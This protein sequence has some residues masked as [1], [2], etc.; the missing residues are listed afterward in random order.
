MRPRFVKTRL[1]AI[2]ALLA[3][4]SCVGHYTTDRAAVAYNRAFANGRNEVLLLNILR[5][6]ADEPLQFSTISSVGGQVLNGTEVSIPFTNILLGGEDSITPTLKITGRNP[7][8]TVTPL[9]TREFVRGMTRSISIDTIV[10]LIDQGWDR[11]TVLA[12]AVGGVVCADKPRNVVMNDG[13]NRD[14]NSRFISALQSAT[15]VARDASA[16]TVVATLQMTSAEAAAMLA[17][18]VGEGRR[19]GRILPIVPAAEEKPSA[20]TRPRP[21]RVPP[22]P[23]ANVSVEIVEPGSPRLSGLQFG[24]LCGTGAPSAAAVEKAGGAGIILRSIQSMIYYLGALHRQRFPADW[25]TCGPLFGSVPAPT[26]AP[27]TNSEPPI[28][29]RAQVRCVAQQI[30]V[31][32]VIATEFRNRHYY[33]PRTD[34]AGT[35]DHTLEVMSLLTELIA[36]QT[37]DDAVAASRPIIAISPQ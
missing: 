21:G 16:S 35:Q 34:E 36:L 12:L 19:V 5:A 28:L 20:T 23:A 3:L 30:P 11:P 24:D 13:S 7:T 26:V 27:S 18:G 31:T 10:N 9:A 4:A 14:L 6:S 29:F 22:S 33:I 37:T 17:E 25:D 2:V 15:N 8:V 1:L 32:A